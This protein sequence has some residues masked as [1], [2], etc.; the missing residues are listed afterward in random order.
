M[1]PFQAATRPAEAL[2]SGDE[3]RPAIVQ[4]ARLRSGARRLLIVLAVLVANF[5]LPRVLPGDPLLALAD[6]SSA[7]YVA[8]P[9]LLARVQA[10]YG[11]DKSVPEQFAAY[12]RSLLTGDL[13]WS[14]RFN[15]PVSSL[16]GERIGWTLA[17][18]LPALAVA[19]AVSIFG[20]LAAGW[21]R[22]SRADR[23]LVW[24]FTLLSS[25]PSYL[26][27]VGL[28]VLFSLTLGWAPLGG[29]VT[30][31]VAAA[32]TPAW[33]ADAA[34]HW[35][36]PSSALAL[37]LLGA[38]FLLART[39]M[40]TTLAQPYLLVAYAKGLDDRRIRNHHAARNA[41]LPVVTALGAAVAFAVGGSIVIETVYA[42][43]GLGLLTYQGVESRDYPL[44]QG[45]FLVTSLVVLAANWAVDA[46]YRRVDPR[47]VSR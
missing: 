38:R 2:I 43:P 34:R 4:S 9:E 47:V 14:I 44:L 24:A 39:A 40:V 21:R 20:G 36:L 41:L 23:S 45:C 42:Y 3:V 17:L 12:L 13:G 16:I 25:V 5:A 22:G 31:F 32:G 18:M 27:A 7:R 30:P 19:S 6:P 8:D 37:S 26:I 29:S 33:W 46:L 28:L 15:R 1:A 10:G 35:A 11:L